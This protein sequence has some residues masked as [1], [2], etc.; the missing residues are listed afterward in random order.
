MSHPQPGAPTHPITQ[1]WTYE[2][3]DSKLEQ[4]QV[5]PTLWDGGYMHLQTSTDVVA[6]A[7]R[8]AASLADEVADA[9]SQGR[10]SEA[11]EELIASAL[12]EM[13]RLERDKCAL[14]AEHRADMWESALERY[15]HSGT[16][17]YA[18]DGARERHKE[19]VSIA[20]AIRVDHA[21]ADG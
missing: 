11:L 12:L 16:P 2:R 14:I 13:M 6:E 18:I 17:V 7:G 9:V 21:T 19:A 1:V 15:R 8:R 10:P 3:P 5:A 20:D 4:Y